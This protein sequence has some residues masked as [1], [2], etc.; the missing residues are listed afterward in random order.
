[1]LLIL[2]FSVLFLGDL[3]STFLYHV[4][5]HV[6]KLQTYHVKIHHSLNR[7][8]LHYAVLTND[9]LVILDGLLGALP[10][11]IVAGLIS[12]VNPAAALLG[13]VLGQVHVWYRHINALN[14]YTPGWLGK[15][16]NLFGI[17]TAEQHQKHHDNGLIAFGDIFTIFDK[18]AQVWLQY[19]R[20]KVVK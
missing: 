6:P 14:L 8:Y 2:A 7:N 4:P 18:P 9:P 16:F 19:L 5:E 1:M 12:L 3:L 20:S 10:Y 11:L 17:V 15:I 13:L